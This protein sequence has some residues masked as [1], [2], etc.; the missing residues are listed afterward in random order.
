MVE[1]L[2]GAID[3][4]AIG[5]QDPRGDVVKAGVV[6]PVDAEDLVE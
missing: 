3:P 4:D 1:K 2:R 6:S 5:S